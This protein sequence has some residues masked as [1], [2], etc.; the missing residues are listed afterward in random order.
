M[1]THTLVMPMYHKIK[2]IFYF[3]KYITVEPHI[4]L[5]G[6]TELVNH[7]FSPHKSFLSSVLAFKIVRNATL[8]SLGSLFTALSACNSPLSAFC[9]RQT[10]TM[11]V[12]DDT[13][14]FDGINLFFLST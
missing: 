4:R 11:T 13:V 3:D 10:Q 14:S 6:I 9:D 5:R 12:A 2:V 1:Y 7:A 8:S